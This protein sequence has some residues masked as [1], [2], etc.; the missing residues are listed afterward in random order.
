MLGIVV[1]ACAILYAVL[2]LAVR[3]DMASARIMAMSFLQTLLLMAAV[4]LSV[5]FFEPIVAFIAIMITVSGPDVV[6]LACR[7][8]TLPGGQTVESY[9]HE[10]GWAL[11]S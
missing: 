5:F 1:V 11:P 7:F 9:L 8:V 3:H 4:A 10:K 2:P 6:S